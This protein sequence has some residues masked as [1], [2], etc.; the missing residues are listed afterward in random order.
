MTVVRLPILQLHQLKMVTNFH[1]IN[2]ALMLLLVQ[3]M[4]Q[5]INKKSIN[6]DAVVVLETRTDEEQ[7][8][9]HSYKHGNECW[10][11]FPLRL[12]KY[13]TENETLHTD[14]H[15]LP[16]LTIGWFCAV[17][18]KDSGSCKKKEKHNIPH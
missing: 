14:T 18:S 9:E 16:V 6:R 10:A 2:F 4:N 17:F 8:D 3:S 7:E 13:T 15:T 11:I 1:S 5:K 12:T